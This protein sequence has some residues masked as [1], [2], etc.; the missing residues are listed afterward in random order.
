M[1]EQCNNDIKRKNI[2]ILL[3]HDDVDQ[4]I[5]GSLE[6]LFNLVL[7]YVRGEKGSKNIDKDEFSLDLV[8]YFKCLYRYLTVKKNTDSTMMFLDIIALTIFY[9]RVFV[10][11]VTDTYLKARIEH[12]IF[13]ICELYQQ[14]KYGID[15]QYQICGYND[16]ILNNGKLFGDDDVYTYIFNYYFLLA[17]YVDKTFKLDF[18]DRLE[19]T[20]FFGIISEEERKILVKVKEYTENG[21]FGYEDEEIG[22]LKE[23]IESCIEFFYIKSKIRTIFNA[24]KLLFELKKF[25]E[26]DSTIDK[27]TYGKDNIQGKR[28]AVFH[29]NIYPYLCKDISGNT[30]WISELSTSQERY[31]LYHYDGVREMSALIELKVNDMGSLD[32]DIMQLVDYLKKVPSKRTLFM[33]EPDFGILI[34]YN[35]GQRYLSDKF[36]EIENS[37]QWILMDNFFVIPNEVKPVFVFTL[38]GKGF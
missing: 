6:L 5:R 1:S 32:D 15:E 30:V 13:Y 23:E 10:A 4:A 20:E 8:G 9:N 19:S 21:L 34:V 24:A 37:D 12:V 29:Q 27:N 28:E 2:L 38:D 3:Q 17:T 7:E 31:D 22:R 35:I 36:S 16:T 25:R 11:Q 26:Y 14:Q 18:W 33:Q